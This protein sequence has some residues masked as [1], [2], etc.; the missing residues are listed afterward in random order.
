LFEIEAG[1]AVVVVVDRLPGTMKMP[2]DFQ[3][4]KLQCSQQALIC[5]AFSYKW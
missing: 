4:T 2:R 3:M 1:V 5:P